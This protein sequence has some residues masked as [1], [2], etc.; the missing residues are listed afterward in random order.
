MTPRPHPPQRHLALLLLILA[1]PFSASAL[2]GPF[3]RPAQPELDNVI[4]QLPDIPLVIDADLVVRNRSGRTERSYQV[5]MELDW[6]APVPTANYTLRDRFGETLAHLAVSWPQDRQPHY[7]FFTGNPLVAAPVPPL[8]SPVFDT[9][10]SWIDLSLSFLW[11]RGG[12]VVGTESVRSRRCLIIDLPAP[13]DDRIQLSGARLWID[14]RI[15]MLLR[16]DGFDEKNERIRRME[17]Q[18]FR[19]IGDRWVIKDIEFRR[20]PARGTTL[21]RVRD[22]TERQR[23]EL[24]PR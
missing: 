11:W 14:P 8:N 19:K 16:A 22:V 18:S 24:P 12:E 9:D 15:G 4:T 10:L 7:R 13:A 6:W 5:E 23:F 1:L 2:E 17:V 21:L 20:Y 3:P